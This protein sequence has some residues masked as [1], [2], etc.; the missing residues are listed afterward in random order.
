VAT[1]CPLDAEG[2]KAV[3][4]KKTKGQKSVFSAAK[5]VS[6]LKISHLQGSMKN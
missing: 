5:A 3:S 2:P 4:F 1:L 6:L